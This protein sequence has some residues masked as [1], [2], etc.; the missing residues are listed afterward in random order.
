MDGNRQT[1]TNYT[2]KDYFINYLLKIRGISQSSANHYV[3][4]LQTTI[5]RYLMEKKLVSQSIFEITD[6]DR[7]VQYEEILMHDADFLALNQ[8]GNRMYSVALHR[9]MGFV[10]GEWFRQSTD[11]QAEI[12]KLDTPILVKAYYQTTVQQYKRSGIIKKQVTEAALYRC[13]ANPD[14]QTFIVNHTSHPYME[15]H[16]VIPLKKQKDFSYSLDVYANVVCLCPVCH[17]LLH[18]GRP[19][20]KERILTKFYDERGERLARSGIELS[21]ADFLGLTEGHV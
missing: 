9:Y 21:R 4:A 11:P 18:Y 13:E 20:D 15:G 12:K 14:H 1:G 10:Q 5:S 8:R 16:H 2:L 6:L 17:R 7:L 3:G 19:E